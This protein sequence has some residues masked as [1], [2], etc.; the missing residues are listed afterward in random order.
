M[1]KNVFTLLWTTRHILVSLAAANLTVIVLIGLSWLTA[2]NFLAGGADTPLSRLFMAPLE[3]LIG[4]LSDLTGIQRPLLL[5]I[6]VSILVLALIYYLCI[7]WLL[8][9]F[10]RSQRS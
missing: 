10:A 2:Q 7:R 3:F 9:P 1:K 8:V 4:L 5:A 6:V